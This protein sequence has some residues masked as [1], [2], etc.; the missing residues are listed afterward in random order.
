MGIHRNRIYYVFDRYVS[1]ALRWLQINKPMLDPF[2]VQHN[3]ICAFDRKITFK[4][5]TQ[6][7]EMHSDGLNTLWRLVTRVLNGISVH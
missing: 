6:S 4:D 2:N 5:N 1:S 7:A 3:S